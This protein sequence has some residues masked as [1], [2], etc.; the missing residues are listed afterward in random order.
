MNDNIPLSLLPKTGGIKLDREK[1]RMGLVLG[2][3]ANALTA[4][5]EVG[6]LG[7]QKYTEHGWLTVPNGL[8]RYTNAM[9]RH[10]LQDP[11]GG[12]LDDGPDGIGTLHAAQ[13]AWNALARLEL[14]LQQRGSK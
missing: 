9:L 4:V 13:V 1:P 5:G 12:K 11:N 3:F 6:T 14:I 2:D 8:E 7:A 10:Y